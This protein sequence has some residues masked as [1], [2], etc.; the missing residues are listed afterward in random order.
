MCAVLVG[1]PFMS[2]KALDWA[3]VGD[4]TTTVGSGEFADVWATT[5]GSYVNGDY[6]GNDAPNAY[7]QPFSATGL[8]NTL[9]I[10][11]NLQATAGVPLL[12][13]PQ[14]PLK[15]NGNVEL[16]A[17]ADNMVININEDVI[18]EPYFEPPVVGTPL[19]VADCSHIYFN[20]DDDKTITVNVNHNLEFRGKTT[21]SD[22]FK[23]LLISFRGT[24]QVNFNLADGTKVSFNGQIDRSGGQVLDPETGL[25][26]PCPD[27]SVSAGG[28][29]VFVLMDQ[30]ETQAVTL[31]RNK[32]VFARAP[33]GDNPEQRVMVHVGPN[34]V[35]TYLSTDATGNTPGEDGGYGAVA[36]DTTNIVGGGTAVGRMVLLISGAYDIDTDPFLP[37][38]EG[39]ELSIPNPDFNKIIAKYP[40]NDGGVVVAGHLVSSFDVDAI[41][42]CSVGEVAA[43]PG[44]DFSTPAGSRAIMRV[45]DTLAYEAAGTESPYAATQDT[46]SG[47]LVVSD[48]A[49]HSKFATDPYWDLYSNLSGTPWAY[50]NP[51]N[52]LINVRK[53]YVVGVN[54]MLDIFHNCF[55]DH[56]AGATNSA[57]PLAACDFAASQIKSRNPAAMKFDGLDVSLFTNGN[58]FN[59][60]ATSAFDAANPFTQA[61]PVSAQVLLRG[62][63]A[64]Y[65]KESASSLWGYIKGKQTFDLI[66]GLDFNWTEILGVGTGTYDGFQLDPSTNE[67]VKQ[68]GEGEHVLD[69][70]GLSEVRSIG[71]DTTVADPGTGTFRVYADF[72]VDS[73]VLNVASLLID[74]Q[75]LEVLAADGTDRI[76]RPI[77]NDGTSYGRYN[78]GTLFLNRSLALYNSILR[79]SDVTKTVDGIPLNSEPGITGGESLWFGLSYWDGVT[80]AAANRLADVN[81]FRTPEIQLFNSTLE[82]QESLCASGVR[83]V[84]KDIPQL[85]NGEGEPLFTDR[86]GDNTSVIR[87]Y[88]HGDPLDT[89]LTGHGRIFLCGSS[90]NTMSDESTNAVTDS[91]YWNIFKHNIPALPF[92]DLTPLERSA[93][94]KLSLQNGDQFAPEVQAV[95]DVDPTFAEK[96]RAHHLFLFAQPDAEGAICNA[97]IGWP[98]ITGDAAG[99]PSTF[100]YP[101]NEPVTPVSSVLFSL[102]SIANPDSTDK[103]SQAIAVPPATLSIDGT[104]MCF[105]SF[106][107]NGISSPVPVQND[108]NTGVVYVKHGGKITITRPAGSPIPG[109]GER[110][111]V[112]YQCCFDTTLAAR[113]WND[114]N[115]NGDKRVIRLSGI[116]DLP[117]D[118]VT[119]GKNYG[120]QPYNI[121]DAM[122][123]A[124]RDQ[125]DGYV[126]MSFVREEDEETGKPVADRSGAEEVNIGWFYREM[127]D[128]SASFDGLDNVHPIKS[129]MMKKARFMPRMNMLSRATE[130]I[131]T[132]FPRPL[133]LLYVGAGDDITQMHVAG[134][135]MSDPFVLDVSGDGVRPLPARVREFTSLQTTAGIPTDRFISEGAHGVLFVEFGGHIGLGSR[136]WN[137]HSLNAWNLLG[138]DY[139]TICPLGNGTVDVNS[140]LLVTDRLALVASD[141]FGTTHYTIEEDGLDDSTTPDRLT[142]FSE[143]AHEIRIPANGELDLSSFGH[144]T[145][146]QE[147]A[148]GGKVKLILEPGATIR[149]PEILPGEGGVV[150]YFNDESELV[151]EEASD[152]NI[153]LPFT[154]A[155]NNVNGVDGT[156]S[157]NTA[158]IANSRCRILGQGQIWVNKNALI[159]VNGNVYVGVETDALTQVTDIT[160]SIQREGRM[161]IG[162]ENVPGGAFQVGNPVDRNGVGEEANEHSINFKLQLNG[163]DSTFNIDRE[164]FFGLGA[165]V[166]NKNG[167]PNGS[168]ITSDNNPVLDASG[169]VVTQIVDGEVVPV[170]NPDVNPYNGEWQVE[171]LY[172][173]NNIVIENTRGIIEHNSI[174]DGS[175]N[176]ASL[177]AIG[178]AASYTISLNGIDNA[179][180]RGGGNLMFVN[181]ASV[182]EACPLKGCPT[183]VDIQDYAGDVANIDGSSVNASYSILGSAPL[184]LD[185]STA[186]GGDLASVGFGANGQTFTFSGINAGGQFFNMLAF[187]PFADQ[188]QK[189]VVIGTTQFG[190]QLAFVNN[191][192]NK[193]ANVIPFPNGN[194]ISRFPTPPNIQGNGVSG[195]GDLQD[196][197]L[198]GAVSAFADVTGQPTNFS[199]VQ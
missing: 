46:R 57:D 15:I 56:A 171:A 55:V 45:I 40:F 44:Y 88:D 13:A 49:N 174:A 17:S 116:I 30:T 182:S 37:S 102:T 5:G 184:L 179:I 141:K 4:G 21:D 101:S 113:L 155:K 38:P 181:F 85:P 12:G 63:A 139:V 132:P 69:V 122:F 41:S 86:T 166:I 111:S 99:Y 61:A 178:P 100:P 87:A 127:P 199:I 108:N 176:D 76:T 159:S 193:Y 151:F 109:L 74:Y 143:L 66:D 9:E 133:D 48:V 144:G 28:T 73:G 136:D 31:Q 84:V 96:Q 93:R 24:G 165:G 95:I 131:A 198:I 75:G 53:G 7:N 67:D 59:G 169:N 51:D 52:A 8:D 146:Q 10:W 39:E 195:G 6:I 152:S 117:H 106:N 64:L 42:G 185:R 194:Q 62:N 34:S 196:A 70:E 77:L 103:P 167:N 58:P 197:L 83:F 19:P 128:L 112:P 125:T 180:V 192:N 157:N 123:A 124:R 35:F 126:R 71:N 156:P 160:I 22:G 14:V 148:F 154:D 119:F 60:G 190:T 138:K 98:T 1:L 147:I 2:V 110:T 173:V 105:G 91:C 118:Q 104:I 172:N 72:V 129:K 186:A 78:S 183:F 25:F 68:S 89:L 153:F 115:L 79:H 189:K 47:L 161:D 164:G 170:F 90:L 65:V 149:F 107:S 20:V 163:D 33:G 134:A 29:K 120:V 32:V 158:P 142:F 94:V 145:K 27:P 80:D 82:L 18:I 97:E 187:K 168:V 43:T 191:V 150:L 26:T 121:T 92:G 50:S 3:P 54:G 140:N 11:G 135:T 114:Y 137:E 188:P 130:S 16:T 36:F 175:S 23:D 81:R 177:M 162:D